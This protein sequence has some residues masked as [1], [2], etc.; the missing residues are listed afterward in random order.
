MIFQGFNLLTQKTVL[1]NVMLPLK[2]AHVPRK[3]QRERALQMTVISTVLAYLIGLPLGILL[4][5]TG[6]DHIL[7]N[8]VVHT[9]LGTIPIVARMVESSLEE[10]SP[11]IIEAAESMGASPAAIIF[12]FILPEA[13]PSLLLGGAINL[14][15]VLGYSAMAGCIG[16]G[17]LGAI[18]LNYGW[19]R[20]QTDVLLIT[21]VVLI[22]IV[23]IFQEAGTILAKKIR[24]S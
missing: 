3:E 6:K 14:A 22:L 1:D 2:I 7:Q 17:G 5:V 20:Y 8:R 16:G 12:R 24:H 11:G 13:M 9:I 18:A 23:Q 21:V 10:V 19:Y 4:V 15:T